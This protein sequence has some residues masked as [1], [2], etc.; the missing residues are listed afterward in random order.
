MNDEQIQT[1]KICCI[2]I[3]T[4]KDS[5]YNKNNVNSSNIHA[6]N[7]ISLNSICDMMT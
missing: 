1:K 3:Y 5:I 4:E 2:V 6:I 7:N